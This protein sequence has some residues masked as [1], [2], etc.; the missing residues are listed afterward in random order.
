METPKSHQSEIESNLEE[1]EGEGEEEEFEYEEGEE[2]EQDENAENENDLQ[3]ESELGAFDRVQ[4]EEQEENQDSRNQDNEN[5]LE[6]SHDNELNEYDQ[7][8]I[9]PDDD[10]VDEQGNVIHHYVD[11]NGE[12]EELD[13][14][15]FS[16][17]NKNMEYSISDENDYGLSLPPD[18]KVRLKLLRFINKL[19]AVYNIHELQL[20]LLGN[21]V[22]NAYANYLLTEKENDKVLQDLAK[23]HNYKGSFNVSTFTVFVDISND[24]GGKRVKYADYMQE[25]EDANATLIEFSADRENMLSTDF[26]TVSIGLAFDAEKVVVVDLFSIKEVD[27]ESCVINEDS[28]N[29]TV[30]GRMLN[31]MYGVYA[32]K[33]FSVDQPNKKLLLINPSN[34][35]SVNTEAGRTFI[36]SFNNAHDV[37][38]DP[39]DKIVDILI[40]ERPNTINYGKPFTEPMN[41]FE[42]DLEFLKLGYRIYLTN[43]P[44]EMMLNDIMNEENNEIRKIEEEEAK[45]H[46]EKRKE[47]EERDY[48]MKNVDGDG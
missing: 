47:R 29:I 35:L 28:G 22:A 33:V 24:T 32:M 43:F 31:N 40:R 21:T 2:A 9:Y 12:S 5:D 46:E 39:S 16:V 18:R 37:I 17:N 20:D 8:E 41:K 7:D 30:K 10:Q 3:N 38:A 45:R 13:S 25:F 4:M 42:R 26:N 14:N 23:K 11:Q 15:E 48:R 44:N 6:N 1:I 19:R 36:G 34:I 27:L